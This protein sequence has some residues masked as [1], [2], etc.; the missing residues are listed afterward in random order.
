MSAQPPD[1]VP[2]WQPMPEPRPRRLTWVK[3][4]IAGLVGFGLIALLC[5]GI[6]VH[7]ALQAAQKWGASL[8]GVPQ[9]APATP[10]AQ[11]CFV[12]A[13]RFVAPTDV[14]SLGSANTDDAG[15]AEVL[16]LA[17]SDLTICD[18]A[19]RR[20]RSFTTA[21]PNLPPSSGPPGLPRP[22]LLSATLSFLS[23]TLSPAVIKRQP[24]I[25]MAC[26]AGDAVVVYDPAGRE[27]L[28]SS[29]PGTRVS[30]LEVADLDADGESEIL[31]GRDSQLGLSC[32]DS[33]GRT[34]WRFAG[35]PDPEVV[36]AADA[37]GD[38]RP[39]VYVGGGVAAGSPVAIADANGRKIGQ[40]PATRGETVLAAADLDGDRKA[41]FLAVAPAALSQPSGVLY[42]SLI[43][44]SS[45]GKETWRMWLSTGLAGLVRTSLASGDFDGDGKGEWL[46]SGPDGTLRA[47]TKDGVELC[48]QGMG[49]FLKALA[50]TPPGKRGGRARVWVAMGSEVLGLDWQKWTG[51]PTIQRQG[52]TG[53]SNVGNP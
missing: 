13:A 4:L 39:E 10:P 25:V 44:I 2:L 19:G 8:I 15:P 49:Q 18:Q 32:L 28:R 14:V 34:V 27:L 48:R 46:V 24:A 37:T 41:E 47:Y 1:P 11:A 42:V 31:V 30:A 23:A 5:L 43:G 16:V 38:G 12:L 50:V 3:W 52:A 21:M 36:V 51:Q 33:K 40:W 6:A 7:F 45:S 17:G 35:V 29:V 22:A 26:R 53:S 20:V 9:P